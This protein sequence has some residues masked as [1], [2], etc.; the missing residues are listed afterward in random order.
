V[1]F[2]SVVPDRFGFPAD[3]GCI[4][5]AT[6]QSATFLLAHLE[7]PRDQAVSTRIN[8]FNPQ[9]QFGGPAQIRDD[10]HFSE[11]LQANEEIRTS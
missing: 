1:A 10:F 5:L 2:F 3:V 9:S 4:G 11:T 8:K 7:L 6:H